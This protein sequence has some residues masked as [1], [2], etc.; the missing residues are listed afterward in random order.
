M[1]KHLAACPPCQE[2]QSILE[3]KLTTLFREPSFVPPPDTVWQN[4]EETVNPPAW[5]TTPQPGSAQRLIQKVNKLFLV[6]RPVWATAMVLFLLLSFLTFGRMQ[7]QRQQKQQIE[8]YLQE[9]VTFFAL[10][11]WNITDLY[12]L[13]FILAT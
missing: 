13:T 10:F 12:E 9:N 5:E 11:E 3:R 4:I 2:F 8:S 1:Q 7:Q 6:P